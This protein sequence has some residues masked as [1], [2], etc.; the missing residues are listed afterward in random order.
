MR[1]LLKVIIPVEPGNA[2][3][4]DGRLPAIME[5]VFADIRPEATYFVSDHGRRCALVVFDM[6]DSARIPAIA[7]PFLQGLNASVEFMPVMNIDELRRGLQAVASAVAT[8]GP[9]ASGVGGARAPRA[10]R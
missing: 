6:A 2:S 3:I 5:Q 10:T 9:S 7:E 4:A 1:T 8:P